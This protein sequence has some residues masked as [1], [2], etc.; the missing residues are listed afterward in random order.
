MKALLALLILISTFSISNLSIAGTN[1]NDLNQPN[2]SE[3]RKFM[4]C[5]QI[6]T[7]EVTKFE[8]KNTLYSCP[9]GYKKTNAG[10]Y[11]KN[12]KNNKVVYCKNNQS[13]IVI[14]SR[15]G[16][17]INNYSITSKQVYDNYKSIGN[18]GSNKDY[19]VVNKTSSSSNKSIT[20][21]SNSNSNQYVSTK[22]TSI[23]KDDLRDELKYWKSLLD[24]GLITEKD[25]N[26]KK[27]E[28]LS[29]S[30]ISNK[31]YS[32]N[33][34]ST[35][36]NNLS[37]EIDSLMNSSN[38]N[39]NNISSS[40]KCSGLNSEKSWAFK[41]L[42]GYFSK[43]EACLKIASYSNDEICSRI[44]RKEDDILNPELNWYQKEISSRG[45]ACIDGYAFDSSDPTT[46]VL[47]TQKKLEEKMEKK[48]ACTARRTEWRTLCRTGDYT[49]V[50]GVL[51]YGTWNDRYDC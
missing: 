30:T 11:K 20:N 49:M 32:S 10:D 43:K 9:T 12:K 22:T 4:Y 27:N 19:K 48:M 7:G 25:Y 3:N 15:S 31:S 13:G 47:Q 51:C 6:N 35:S 50:N 16:L 14:K 26:S 28:L 1:F 34:N 42:T 21:S 37:S 45:V 44:E 36:N 24:D 17:C 38:S 5:K 18:S 29:N 41:G 40:S 2:S 46:K 33:S 23:N 8:K 39:S